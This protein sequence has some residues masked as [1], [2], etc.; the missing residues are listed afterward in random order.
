MVDFSIAM[1]VHQ[2]VH[3]VSLSRIPYADELQAIKNGS[4]KSSSRGTENGQHMGVSENSVP[5]NPMV[6]DHYPY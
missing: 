6:N 1:L 5:L 3:K 4:R 2:R